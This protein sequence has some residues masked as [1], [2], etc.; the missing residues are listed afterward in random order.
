MGQKDVYFVR[1]QTQQRAAFW[2]DKFIRKFFKDII[3]VSRAASRVDLVDSIYYFRTMR[4]DIRGLHNLIEL[5][6]EAIYIMLDD[7]E[8]KRLDTYEGI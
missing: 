2:M 7:P 3:Q 8:R 4:E 6:E 5:P 1:F